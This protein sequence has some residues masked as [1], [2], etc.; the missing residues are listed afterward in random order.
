MLSGSNQILSE[1]SV[2]ECSSNISIAEKGTDGSTSIDVEVCTNV[3]LARSDEQDL[4]KSKVTV[5]K[6]ETPVENIIN[7]VTSTQIVPRVLE[8][9]VG[10]QL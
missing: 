2:Q 4:L 8:E 9:Q 5:E 3:K 1:S 6:N 10:P 7:Q